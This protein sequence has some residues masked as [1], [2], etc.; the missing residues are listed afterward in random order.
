MQLLQANMQVL[1]PK[2]QIFQLSVQV[3]QKPMQILQVRSSGKDVS[4][5]PYLEDEGSKTWTVAVGRCVPSR[6]LPKADGRLALQSLA[7]SV[8]ITNK[9]RALKPRSFKGL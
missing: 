4:V 1:Q 7:A 9:G 5:L 6:V 8:N 3:L 2:M